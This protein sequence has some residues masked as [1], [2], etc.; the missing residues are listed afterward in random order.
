MRAKSL[1]ISLILIVVLTT[2]P[3]GVAFADNQSDLNDVKQ[4]QSEAQEELKDVKGD[5]QEQLTEL[6]GLNEKVAAKKAEISATKTKIKKVE[7]Q[8]DKRSTGLN[9]RLR[10]MYKKGNVGYLDVVL[11]SSSISEL[12]SNLSMLKR[13]VNNDQAVVKELSE[14]K[15]S[16]KK[17]HK[18]LKAEEEEL[19]PLQSK[20]KKKAKSLEGRKAEI[21]ALIKKLDEEKADIEAKIRAAEEAAAQHGPT[22]HFDGKFTWPYPGYYTITSPFGYRTHPVTGQKYKFHEGTDIGVPMGSNVVAAASGTVILA[23]WYGGYGNYVSIRHGDG[24]VTCYGHNSR[25]L[26]HSGQSVKRGQVIAKSGSTGVSSGPHGHFEVRINGSPVNP[27][28]YF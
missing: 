28:Q 7:K 27:M 12:V 15:A 14:Q 20:A 21:E 19:L 17:L 1:I 23:Q 6:A 10:V 18:S 4:K 11:G 5:L 16:L 22:I 3:C 25:I 26:V 2:I 8:I 9:K 24:T 13:I